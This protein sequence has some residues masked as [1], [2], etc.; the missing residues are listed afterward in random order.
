M[1]PSSPLGILA[2]GAADLAH[3]SEEIYAAAEAEKDR[4]GVLG[5]SN[6]LSNSESATNNELLT[7]MYF[8]DMQGLHRFAH[9]DIHR[10]GW[11][12]WNDHV[13]KLPHIAI[14]HEAYNVPKG[15]WESIYLNTKPTMLGELLYASL[16]S[17]LRQFL[18]W[19]YLLVE[20]LSHV[21]HSSLFILTLPPDVMVG[22]GANLTNAGATTH[23]RQVSEKN[24]TGEPRKLWFSPIVDA[25]KGLMKTMG[26]RMGATQGHEHDAY[27][28]ANAYDS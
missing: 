15:H 23:P 27:S 10:K 4:Y 8:R 21:Q 7:L 1:F 3:I 18:L 12:W 6:W 22:I 26:G 2:P 20:C 17:I 11:K 28:Y 14:W 16:G 24:E 13:K 9:D 5:S 25:R 19:K